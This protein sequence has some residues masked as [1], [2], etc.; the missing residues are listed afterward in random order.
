MIS[1]F[2]D[3]WRP[4]FDAEGRYQGDIGVL[5]DITERKQMEEDLRQS[6]KLQSIGTLAG[7]IAHDLNNLLV[8]I[9]GLT[10][11]T[12]EHLPKG[13]RDHRNLEN[14][15]AAAERAQRLVE[16]ILAFSR[17]DKPSRRLL[18]LTKVVPEVLSL[19]R[20]VVPSSVTIREELDPGTPDVLG[21][22]TQIH[23]VLM[24]LASN[25]ASAMGIRGGI[26]TIQ[27]APAR[28][29]AA[30]CQLHPELTPG[31]AARLCVSDTGRGMDRETL[32]RIFEPF[33]TTKGVGEGTGLG[34]SVVHGIVTAHGG[35]V[36]VESIVG[37]GTTFT[38]YIPAA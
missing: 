4:Q 26:L 17:R 29:D 8:P 22:S 38:I 2:L 21:D 24:N 10:E 13:E 1:R 19:L 5:V 37:R 31:R 15:I 7:G 36:D 35:A 28:L 3:L 14:V 9:L 11:L 30:F 18:N 32:K 12:M 27:V 25:A 33:F 16:Q 23:Q 34:L 6:Q 20:S